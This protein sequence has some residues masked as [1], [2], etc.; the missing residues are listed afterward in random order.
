[1]GRC[2]QSLEACFTL[3]S[4]VLLADP[5]MIQGIKR[6]TELQVSNWLL[7]AWSARIGELLLDVG[8]QSGVQM[9]C[10]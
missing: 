1:M 8:V 7:T 10:K 6:S 5:C 4:G 2:L 9:M 3:L